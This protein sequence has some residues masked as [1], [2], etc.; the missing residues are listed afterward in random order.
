MRVNCYKRKVDAFN[1]GNYRGLKLIHQILRVVEKAREKLVSQY[2]VI[3]EM[4][5]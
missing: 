5:F 3:N 1:R 2:M 4:Q